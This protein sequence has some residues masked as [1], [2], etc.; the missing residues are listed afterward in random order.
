MGIE[1]A[2]MTA[3]EGVYVER[4]FRMEHNSL[5]QP[6]RNPPPLLYTNEKIL[7][8]SNNVNVNDRFQCSIWNWSPHLIRYLWHEL[9][10]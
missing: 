3:A 2:L 7:Q 6:V 5:F 4:I 9:T 8:Q 10:R 1:L